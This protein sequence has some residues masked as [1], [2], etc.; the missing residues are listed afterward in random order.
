MIS[1]VSVPSATT[2]VNKACVSWVQW[3]TRG[4]TSVPR[5]VT[6][7]ATR[8]PQKA[9]T[10]GATFPAPDPRPRPGNRIR[11][12]HL[13]LGTGRVVRHVSWAAQLPS[14]YSC[15]IR[16]S[17][18]SGDPVSMEHQPLCLALPRLAPSGFGKQQSGSPLGG[19]TTG[20]FK[21][22]EGHENN[23]LYLQA[24]T[25]FDNGGFLWR[26]LAES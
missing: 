8:K 14:V 7:E 2:R 6:R 3:H 9:L 18:F 20:G 21:E 4:Q 15:M 11:S 25:F 12:P 19:E 24:W 26:G 5:L 13:P 17:P 23:A 22:A 10:S 16:R 1:P